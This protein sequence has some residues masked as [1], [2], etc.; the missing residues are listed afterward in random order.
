MMN[1]L[2]FKEEMQ[3]IGIELNDDQMLQFGD[4]LHLLQ[5][6]SQ[7][8]NLTAIKD[9]AGIIEKHFYDSLLL[10]KYLPFDEQTTMLDIG[11][12]AGF[13]G[14]PL[15]IAFPHLKVT[16][17]EPVL[18]KVRFL[19]R[20]INELKL[21]DIIVVVERAETYAYREYEQFDLVTARA[22][23]PLNILLELGVPLAKVEGLVVAYK[24]PKA[25]EEI[26]EAENALQILGCHLEDVFVERLPSDHDHRSLVVIKKDIPTPS[27]FPRKYALIKKQPL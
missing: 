23:A 20:V 15:K 8:M 12:G 21:R 4:Y 19:A 5:K 13:P 9:E 17:L 11:T 10:A 7:R 2:I 6:A 27:Q 18:K 24:G 1:L 26:K 16:L 22:V 3:K 25:E 14:I